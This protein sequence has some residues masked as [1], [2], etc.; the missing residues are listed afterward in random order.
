[1]AVA[2]ELLEG[3]EYRDIT[4][5]GRDD[6]FTGQGADDDG[7]DWS[8]ESDTVGLGEDDIQQRPVSSLDP[9]N[10]FTILQR[11]WFADADASADWRI[12]A[13]EDLGFVA[14]EQ[15]SSEDKAVLDDAHRPHVVFNRFLAIVKAIAGMEING[16]HEIVFTPTET[17]DTVVS[18]ILSGTSRS[19]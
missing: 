6:Y 19:I 14:G 16:R 17:D 8:S 18:E 7:D 5:R 11:W 12:Q 3:V 1:M 15:L 2:G 13:T 10:A 4:K 9:R